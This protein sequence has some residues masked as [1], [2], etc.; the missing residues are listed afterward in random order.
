VTWQDELQHLDAEL[1][2]G[3]ISAEDYRMRRD[4]ALGRAQAGQQGP[5]SGGFP[6]QGQGTPSGGFPQQSQNPFPPAFNWG[7]AARAGQQQQQQQ[8]GSTESTQIVPNPMTGGQPSSNESESTQVVNV[9]QG[10]QFQ[11]QPQG[12]QP[13]QWGQ[14]QWPS[15]GNAPTTPWDEPESPEHGDTSWM[16]QGPEVFETAGKSSKGTMIAGVSL[17]VLLL[18]GVIV[19]AVFY[20]T[21]SGG[22]PDPQADK[23]ATQQPP[24]PTTSSLPEPPPAK[25]APPATPQEVLVPPPPP[26][27]PHP[28]N[29]PVDRPGLEGPRGGL[30]PPD[31]RSFA[32]QNGVLGGWFNGT[33]GT[34]PRTTLLAMQMPDEQGASRLSKTYLDGQNGL[35]EVKDLSYQGVK[36]VSTGTGTL[37]TAYTSHNWTI[38]VDVSVPKGQ[39]QAAQDLFENLLNQQLTQTPPTVRK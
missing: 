21:S 38:I 18:V 25:P 1:A 31:V 11:Q 15:T 8:G 39:E 13:Q 12:W 33:D 28:F 26:G 29:G 22:S 6:Q 5:P 3:R 30:L 36:V 14:Q 9:N 7:E 37:R 16:R 20:F 24:P 35:A 4:A 19:A 10:G 23:P 27:P 2:A 17:G 34:T 32:L